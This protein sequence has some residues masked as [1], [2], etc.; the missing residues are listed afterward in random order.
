MKYNAAYNSALGYKIPPESAEKYAQNAV[1][2]LNEL[3]IQFPE[4]YDEFKAPSEVLTL[5]GVRAFDTYYE[6]GEN[7]P[8]ERVSELRE[9]LLNNGIV[10]VEET[11]VNKVA[12]KLST[13]NPYSVIHV[14]ALNRISDR[15]TENA[16][17]TAPDIDVI[18]DAKSFF[19]WWFIW[20]QKFT[21]GLQGDIKQFIKNDVWAGHSATFGMLLGYPGEAIMSLFWDDA[22]VQIAMI[23]AKVLHAD[24][25]DQAWPR[26][27]YVK[28]L[29]SNDNI[30]A[31]EKLWSGI[32]ER[33]YT[34]LGEL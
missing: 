14:A 5:S 28:D 10:L 4:F 17:F 30:V 15:Y 9:F 2:I 16:A 1:T 6:L 31:H 20:K 33:V 19:L 29:E 13:D 23:E 25:F 7:V 12:G 3:K 8:A 11:E 24:K 34:D 21:D 26:Y 22:D 18:T 32:L 27:D